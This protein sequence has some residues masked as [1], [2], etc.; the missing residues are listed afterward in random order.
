MAK[1]NNTELFIDGNRI[2]HCTQYT[3]TIG[4]DNVESVGI[5]FYPL[6]VAE[7]VVDGKREIRIIT[8]LKVEE[9]PR[10]GPAG[11]CPD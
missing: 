7:I 1:V 9:P 6:D 2:D 3:R 5:T 8:R 11:T 10:G 4:F